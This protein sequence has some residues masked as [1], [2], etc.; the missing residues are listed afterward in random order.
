MG[1]GDDWSRRL[2]GCVNYAVVSDDGRR[3]G[4]VAY[5]QYGSRPDRPDALAIRGSFLHGR[6]IMIVS[7]EHVTEVN[8]DD[9]VVVLRAMPRTTP[10][11][12]TT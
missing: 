2:G 10:V 7:V 4:M 9:R 3:V 12:H 8:P 11:Q 6:R 1:V 5:V